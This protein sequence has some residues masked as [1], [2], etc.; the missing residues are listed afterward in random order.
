MDWY[1]YFGNEFKTLL[2]VDGPLETINFYFCIDKI[3]I[4]EFCFFNYIFF[5]I[6]S[7]ILSSALKSTYN[8][9]WRRKFLKG[10]IYIISSAGIFY[11]IYWFLKRNE[12][13]REETVVQYLVDSYGVFVAIVFTYII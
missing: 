2:N 7:I 4:L 11:F 10:F 3:D 12:L 8:F 13:S 1:Y 5:F 6:L 9:S